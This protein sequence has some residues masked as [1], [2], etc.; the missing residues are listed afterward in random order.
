MLSNLFKKMQSEQEWEDNSATKDPPSS[1]SESIKPQ[2]ASLVLIC[3]QDTPRPKTEL[4][5]SFKS[6]GSV[7][8]KTKKEYKMKWKS[9]K[10]TINFSTVTSIFESTVSTK[11]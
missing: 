3:Q 11:K 9:K 2:F 7:S 10:V 4:K 1:D 6:I 8:S 5:I